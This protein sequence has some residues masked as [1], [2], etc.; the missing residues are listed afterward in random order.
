MAL[1]V[2]PLTEQEAA[3][4]ERLARS[5]TAPHRVVQ[6]AQIVWASAQGAMV[7]AIARQVGL[8]AFRVRAWL[9]RF[10]RHSL[11]GLADA[12]RSGRPRQHAETA[13]GTVIAPARPK[14]QS[15]GLPCAL[16][17]LARLQQALQERHGL[18]V[19]PATIWKWLQAEGLAW[20]RQQSWFQVRVDVAFTETRGP[21]SR[22]PRRQARCGGSSASMSWA[23]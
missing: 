16:W 17:T 1:K 2:R 11:A 19:T 7:P 23:P 20:K 18:W 4:L 15:L 14:P 13:R 5:R 3:A 6:R 9:H 22:P 10:N 21:S 8:S 12:P